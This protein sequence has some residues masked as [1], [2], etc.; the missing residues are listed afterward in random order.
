MLSYRLSKRTWMFMF[1]LISVLFT[2]RTIAQNNSFV[3]IPESR[4]YPAMHGYNIEPAD[5]FFVIPAFVATP[6]ITLGEYKRF[7]ADRAS[8]GLSNDS[9]MPDK[10][11]ADEET[12]K[13]YLENKKYESFPVLGISW[14]NALEYCIWKTQCEN[15]D[16]GI[17]FIYRL[18]YKSEWIQMAQYADSSSKDFEIN[19][20]Y[21]EWIMASF[22]E[23]A[24]SYF[25]KKQITFPLEYLY[26]AN[27][28]DPQVLKRMCI[29]GKSFI[30]EDVYKMYGYS[31]EGYRDVGF[32]M[33]KEYLNVPGQPQSP[34]LKNKNLM[35]LYGITQ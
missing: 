27:E 32:R 18:P 31:S 6:F 9:L 5:T 29:Y 2:G 23:S 24:N 4:F 8:M 35:Q 34:L 28:T 12:Y 33:V 22:D 15:P 25:G 1:V 19:R 17:A 21:A 20:H 30:S 14:L 10:T 26:V 11:I 3:I 16:S 13:A 7:L